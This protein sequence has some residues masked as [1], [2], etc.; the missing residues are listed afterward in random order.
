MMRGIGGP[1]VGPASTGK[2]MM[3]LEQLVG[4]VRHLRA[5]QEALQY[6][7][8][9]L[10]L[11]VNSKQAVDQATKDL[12]TLKLEADKA[13]QDKEAQFRLIASKERDHLD[14]MATL[15]EAQTSV[16]KNEL[17]SLGKQVS[18]LKE[19]IKLG[20]GMEQDQRDRI[21]SLQVEITNLERD[22][23]AAEG[24]LAQVKAAIASITSNLAKV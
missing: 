14:K 22:K 8:E 19:S 9:A 17:I 15:S 21:A 10:T 7:D 24:D 5:Q 2:D 3:E 16:V 12:V 20:K 23:R 4:V 6:L 13:K 1:F 11:A 18:D